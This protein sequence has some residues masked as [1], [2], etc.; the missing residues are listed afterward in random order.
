MAGT[1]YIARH[2]PLRDQGSPDHLPRPRQHPARVLLAE[3]LLIGPPPCR[4]RPT[5]FGFSRSA[6]VTPGLMTCAGPS[7]V[8]GGTNGKDGVAGPIPAGHHL[9][10]RGGRGSREAACDPQS[11]G[12]Q[13]YPDQPL[14]QW[15]QPPCSSRPCG[16]VPMG[17]ADRKAPRRDPD[18]RA[19]VA[20]GI[21][22]PIRRRG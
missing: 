10:I 22:G 12:G 13:P 8:C 11:A 1:A 19:W 15:G 5:S 21:S 4:W 3:A 20:D 9:S 6:T 14:S 18:L 7:R 17:I 16:A 2:R